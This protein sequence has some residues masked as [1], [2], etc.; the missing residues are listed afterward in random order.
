MRNN[1]VQAMASLFLAV[2]IGTFAYGQ[3]EPAAAGSTTSGQYGSYTPSTGFRL[4]NTDKGTVNLKIFTYL[5]YLNQLGLDSTYTNS[6]GTTSSIDR[7]QDM[8]LNKV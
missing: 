2:M 5:R 1:I 4:V 7:R 3:T 6:F 8:Q